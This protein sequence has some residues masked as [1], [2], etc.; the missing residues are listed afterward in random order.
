MTITQQ[1]YIDPE[2]GALVFP[3]QPG[4]NAQKLARLT[5][6]A[7]VYLAEQVQPKS[8]AFECVLKDLKLMLG[9]Q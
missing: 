1:H 6:Q 7:V 4:E 8:S 2:S 9:A 5:A 3:E